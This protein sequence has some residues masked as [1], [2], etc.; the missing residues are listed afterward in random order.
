V[1]LFRRERD[2]SFK[3]DEVLALLL[4]GVSEDSHRSTLVDYLDFRVNEKLL[5]QLY[6][7]KL[8]KV[9]LEAQDEELKWHKW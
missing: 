9:T 6:E 1:V 5:N 4:K 8:L 2:F 3:N 7:I